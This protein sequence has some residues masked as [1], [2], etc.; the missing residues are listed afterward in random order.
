MFKTFYR[1]VQKTVNLVDLAKSF[2]T[3]I[4]LQN[5]ASIQKRTSPV[6]FAHLAEKLGNGLISNLSTKVRGRR[7]LRHARFGGG[8]ADAVRGAQQRPRRGGAVG[9]CANEAWPRRSGIPE[10]AV[11]SVEHIIGSYPMISSSNASNVCDGI[12][13]ETSS[14]L[15]KIR[16][17]FTVIDCIAGN[18]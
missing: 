9:S 3:N 2:P 18:V 8:L 15:F 4:F 7:G 6:K 10:Q 12:S 11:N 13:D 1:K 5:L 14:I 17:T 16:D